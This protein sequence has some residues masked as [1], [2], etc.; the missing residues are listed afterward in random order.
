[1][2]SIDI[3]D[4]EKVQYRVA[5]LHDPTKQHRKGKTID[6]FIFS[7]ICHVFF[8]KKNPITVFL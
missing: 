5:A 3:E 1:M 8:T 4:I 6:V 2:C 7:S